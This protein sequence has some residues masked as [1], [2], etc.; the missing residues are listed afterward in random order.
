MK[1]LNV[2]QITTHDTGRHLGCYGRP[3]LT[4]PNIDSLAADGVRMTNYFAA[5]PICC[6]SRASMLTGLHPQRHGLMDL[7]FAP[8]DWRIRDDVDH[9]AA[10]LSRNEYRTMLFGIQHEAAHDDADR[11]G[12]DERR[13]TEGRPP[14][15]EIAAE[16]ARYITAEAGAD[17][18]FYAQIGFFET[19]T[20][21]DFGGTEPDTSKGV[22]IPPYLVDDEE[23]RAAMAG[24]QGAVRAADRAVGTIMEAVRSAGIEDRTLFVYTTDHGIEVPRAK[25]TLYDPGIAIALVMRC[26]VAGLTGGRTCDLPAGNV[27]YTPTILDILGLNE[28]I[29]FDGRSFAP[30]LHGNVQPT[31]PVFAMYHKT[32][33]RCVRTETM[34]LIRYFDAATD[35]ARVPVSYGNV[36][37][38]RGIRGNVELFDLQNDPNELNCLAHD[39]AYAAERKKLEQ[40]LW[41]WME[42]V[43]DPLLSGPVATPS[44]TKAV[45]DYREWKEK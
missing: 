14:C 3:T 30:A 2:V 9:L 32:N 33:A 12:F 10:I 37:A 22:E 19:H 6:A 45:A 41:E 23:S 25:W 15:D 8:F 4:T 28:D 29:D 31:R 7:C 13:C 34:K 16:A 27:G 35:Y 42:N 11:L 18:P 1:P 39:P 21:F 20:P 5:V 24:F 26:P 40:L 36:L 44:Y 43:R 17:E 38:K